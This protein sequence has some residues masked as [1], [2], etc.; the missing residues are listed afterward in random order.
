MKLVTAPEA[1]QLLCDDWTLAVSGFGGFG[2]PE[3]ITN[4]VEK[5]FLAAAQP[6]NVSLIFAASN[7]DRKTRGMNHFAHEGLIRRVIAGG[8]RG[9]PLLGQLALSGAIEA[10]NWPQGVLC[11]IFR[12]TAAGQP[13]TSGGDIPLSW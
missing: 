8:W 7:G 11:Q 5:R 4:A 12:S 2:H 1:A 10:Y 13:G 3:A 9:T 6:R